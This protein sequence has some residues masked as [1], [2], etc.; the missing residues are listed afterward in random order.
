L[1]ANDFFPREVAN[2]S[3]E[4]WFFHWMSSKHQELERDHG[5]FRGFGRRRRKVLNIRRP[6]LATLLSDSEIRLVLQTLDRKQTIVGIWNAMDKYPGFTEW[7]SQLKFVYAQ[8]VLEAE[9]VAARQAQRFREIS[10]VY[11]RIFGDVPS[12]T[13]LDMVKIASQNE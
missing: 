12:N 10:A 2:V 13:C 5:E 8:K 1:E 4:L 6:V 3:D 11:T 9:E 7:V